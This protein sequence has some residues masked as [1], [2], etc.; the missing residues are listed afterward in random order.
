[1]VLNLGSNPLEGEQGP[2]EQ[3]LL[4]FGPVLGLTAGGFGEM[5]SY[6]DVLV[7]LIATKA[8]EDKWRL[9]GATSLA[10]AKQTFVIRVH[11]R[12]P[13]ASSVRRVKCK[14]GSSTSD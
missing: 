7:D 10:Q 4:Q 3:R 11:G 1:M 14:Y 9:M 2:I 13:T 6:M 8:A 5:N 12:P